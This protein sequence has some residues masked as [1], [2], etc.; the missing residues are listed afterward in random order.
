MSIYVDPYDCQ[1]NVNNPDELTW[2]VDFSSANIT[3]CHA[4]LA[5]PEV[6]W[7]IDLQDVSTAIWTLSLKHNPELLCVP[8]DKTLAM[9]VTGIAYNKFA[10][11]TA[12]ITITTN[13]TG[14]P[15][16][17]DLVNL[18]FPVAPVPSPIPFDLNTSIVVPAGATRNLVMS[19]QLNMISGKTG[20]YPGAKVIVTYG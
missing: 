16:S 20:V 1:G 15:G 6:D 7:Y 10:S 2:Y 13:Y 9:Q 8:A 18:N 19:W 5:Y 3:Y 4:T 12:R 17:S 14:G 11:D